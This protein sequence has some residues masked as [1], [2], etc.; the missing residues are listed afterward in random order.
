MPRVRQRDDVPGKGLKQRASGAWVREDYLICD[1]YQRGKGCTNGTH[2]N[3]VALEARVLD[4]ALS[5]AMRDDHFAAP[6]EVIALEQAIA[7]R[8]RDRDGKR[9]R[10]ATAMTLHLESGR[11]EP[12]AAWLDLSAAADADDDLIEEL[13]GKLIVARGAVP[14]STREA[15]PRVARAARSRRRGRSLRRPDARHGRA[16]RTGRDDHLRDEGGT[17]ARRNDRAARPRQSR[18]GAAATLGGQRPR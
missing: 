8:A 15:R 10:A 5:V 11:P 12:K 4:S 2:F 13:R 17:A 1:S 18:Q 9:T 16:A 3:Y 7:E 14:G 6:A